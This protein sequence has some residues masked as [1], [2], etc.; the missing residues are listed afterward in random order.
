MKGFLFFY[1]FSN[2]IID[3]KTPFIVVNIPIHFL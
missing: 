3:E 2:I 1:I